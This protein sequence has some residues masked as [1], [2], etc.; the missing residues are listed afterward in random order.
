M[1]DS[2]NS[3]LLQNDHT[4][5]EIAVG[6]AGG[7]PITGILIVPRQLTAH[8]IHVA[9]RPAV[10]VYE[11]IDIAF[12]AFTRKLRRNLYPCAV[13]EFGYGHLYAGLADATFI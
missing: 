1:N 13:I 5:H 9:A 7:I 10:V 6:L 12:T 2:L 4:C 8:V 3:V 11:G